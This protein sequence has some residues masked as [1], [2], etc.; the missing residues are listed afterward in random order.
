MNKNALPIFLLIATVSIVVN[1]VSFAYVY[2]R[3]D[4]TTWSDDIARSFI[5]SITTSISLTV[6]TYMLI[7]YLYEIKA[8]NKDEL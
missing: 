8:M 1:Y 5:I 7:S 4:F 2:D 6:I 3:M